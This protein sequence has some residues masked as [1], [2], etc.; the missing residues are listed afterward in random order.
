MY[1]WFTIKT[2]MR[3]NSN[4]NT[5]CCIEVEAHYLKGCRSCKL[6]LCL[7]A[8]DAK[9]TVY[10]VTLWVKIELCI[11]CCRNGT[12][13]LRPRSRSHRFCRA[14]SR[15]RPGRERRRRWSRRRW[16][17]RTYK[18]STPEKYRGRYL[19][20]SW[21]SGSPISSSR[22]WSWYLP[23]WSGGKSKSDLSFV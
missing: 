10:L 22:S 14:G 15:T 3:N 8:K 23:K 6:S 19:K 2:R 17:T 9:S 4:L 16:P 5:T 11:V 20:N 1:P 12:I 7:C 18:C 13:T 21:F